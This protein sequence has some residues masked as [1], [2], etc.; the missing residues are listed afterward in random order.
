MNDK[1]SR[2][3]L[4]RLGALTAA[5][6]AASPLLAACG[7]A[8]GAPAAK[9]QGLTVKLP[10]YTPLAN[11][12]KADLPG[13]AAGVP[14]GFFTYPKQLIRAVPTPPLS[15]ATITAATSTFLP[16]PPPRA[17]NPAWQ[18][19]EKRLGGKVELT[20][21]AADD[22]QTKFNTMVAGNTLPDL[23]QYTAGQGVNNLPAF[24]A[25]Q[26]AD[27]TALLSGDAIKAYPNLAAIPEIFWKQCIV[28][29]RLY[30]LPIPRNLVGG[31]GF[32]RAEMFAEAGITDLAQITDADRLLEALKAVT[33]PDRGRWGVI[34]ATGGLFGLSIFAQLFGAPNGWR[35]DKA[36]GKL[37]AG[38]ETEEYKAAVEFVIK[39]REAGV[40]YPGS[41]G[42]D[43]LKR[44]NEFNSG[45]A[46]MTYDGLPAYLGPTGYLQTQK[47]IDPKADPRPI[48]PFLPS[49][50][51]FLNNIVYAV[52]LVK[53]G[54]EAHVKDVL[55]VADFF[56]SPFGSEEYTLVNYGVEGT[57]HTRDAKGN[58]VLTEAGAKNT[59]VPWKYL[60][61][62]TQP[63][64]DASSAEAV[65]IQHA[66]ISKLIAVGVEDPTAGLYSPAHEG[67][68]ESLNTLRVD[69]LTSIIAG[70]RPMSHYD[71]VVKDWRAAGGDQ[72]RKEFEEVIAKG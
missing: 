70:R 59:T 50:K 14:D 42:F 58:P 72:A 54:D 25:S 11:A 52:N 17:Q 63:I 46:A 34:T 13:T 44:K 6:I 48:T 19:I 31:M 24:A 66:A 38:F 12:L 30:G 69:G 2:R 39:L 28:G 16:P 32:Y 8:G 45:K 9:A 3:G 49:A 20:I 51:A 64:F 10:T 62:P 18:E 27:L 60:G 41:E 35:L 56:S 55:K 47:K 7:N 26:C 15:G 21:V 68:F 61:A 36:T 43:S 53:K 4:L 33:D 67:K 40:I 23:F 22:W 1:L 29:G 37:T 5:G 71:Q 65:R 57:D